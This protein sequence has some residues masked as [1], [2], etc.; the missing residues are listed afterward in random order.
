V[1]MADTSHMLSRY[2]ALTSLSLVEPEPRFNSAATLATLPA[3]LVDL[4]LYVS[5]PV[6][7]LLLLRMT[8]SRMLAVCSIGAG[9]CQT[10]Q[11]RVL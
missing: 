1:K 3:T 2:G 6:K 10:G 9:A 4:K 8:E 5:A 7:V 11:N